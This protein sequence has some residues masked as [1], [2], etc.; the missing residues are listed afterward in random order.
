MQYELVLHDVCIDELLVYS[1]NLVS[2]SE[3]QIVHVLCGILSYF[4]PIIWDTAQKLYCSVICFD[5]Y[6]VECNSQQEVLNCN[7]YG[8]TKHLLEGETC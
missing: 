4:C 8:C 1:V 2:Q 3:N 7:G 5:N 6:K